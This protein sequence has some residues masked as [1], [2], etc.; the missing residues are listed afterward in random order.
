MTLELV[1][2]PANSGKVACLLD[3]FCAALDGDADPWLI[4]PNRPD[5][6]AVERELAGRLGAL[7][8]GRVATFDDLFDEVLGRCR[9]SAPTVSPLQR[10]ML[11]RRI[12][13]RTPL[14]ALAS[15][16]RFAGFVDALASLIEELEAGMVELHPPAAADGEAGDLAR[17][18][19]AYR[20][21]LESI[22]GARDAAGGRAHAAGLLESRLDAW[23]ARPVLV[24]GF[25]DMT[26]AQERSLVALA[27]RCAVTVSLP[28]E[29]ANPAYAAVR[30][31]A[32]RLAAVATQV[33]ELVP[34]GHYHS[35]VLAHLERTLFGDR[36]PPPAPRPD[37]SVV[38]LEA[39]GRRGVAELV[40]AQVLRL[41]GEGVAADEI[42][43]VVP[44]TA[45]DRLALDA[46]FGE[47][48]LPYAIDVRVP[49][50]ETAFGVA[51][52]GALRFAWASGE[53]P[54]LFAWLRS[55]WSGTARRRVDYAE[56]R[57]RGRGLIGHE[58]TREAVV[59]HLG[60]ASLAAIDGLAGGDPGEALTRFV[61]GML[62]S[63]HGLSA[64]F[65]SGPARTGV[66]AGRAVLEAV[67][68]ARAI[69]GDGWGDLL[70]LLVRVQVRL[71]DEAEPGRVSVLDLRRVRT[72]RFD[73]VF[74]LGL[75]EG[76]LPG[77]G[78][79]RRLL[80]ADAAVA[81]GL[82]RIDPL[83]HD[84][85]LFTIACTRPWRRLMLARQAADDDGRPL[86]PS[87]FL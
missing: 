33:R 15:S 27:A 87:P 25:E 79:D 16:A 51:L 4:V 67:E 3:R 31:L 28:Y 41:L 17:L 57:L 68:Q 47:L 38:A 85:H 86:E 61:R 52:L 29:V 66:R 23:G 24:H 13:A 82:R 34:P 21:E 42:A 75:E 9:A 44:S 6:E 40:A 55:P 60:P 77:G 37:G 7:V 46:A 12:V 10:R 18:V 71:G 20:A 63:S 80:D 84:R 70:E 39:C 48:G 73:T 81:A 1:L 30:G 54:D 59:E 11:L 5:V 50:G 26:A 65:L 64:G 8:G 58:E 45:A 35:P 32:E 53:R 19:D 78:S 74:V 36:P 69:A 43:V 14:T 49:L 2:G 72:R 76:A 62:R 22:G 83:E 56:G